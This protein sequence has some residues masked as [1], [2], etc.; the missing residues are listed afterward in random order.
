MKYQGNKNRIVK[1]ILPI[2]MS[3]RKPGQWYVEPFCGSCSVLQHVSESRIASDKNKY[4]IAMWKSLTAGK[5][6]PTEIVK[7]FYS[8]V[9]N[10]FNGKT[11]LKFLDM[12]KNFVE[13]GK[14]SDDLIGWVG[15]MAS[16]NGRFFDG[17][18]SGHKVMGSNGKE[19]DYIRENIANTM[20]QVP[21]LQDVQWQ[22]GDYYNI[23]IPPNSLIYCDPP[24]RNTKEYQ[25]S[26]GFDYDRFYDW[27]V[28]MTR[29]GHTVL[30]S[31]YEMP[32]D[33]FECIWSKEVTNA[34]NPTNTKKA[35]EK[36]FKVK[37]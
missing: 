35:V 31:E 5:R 21:Y 15:Y 19:R 23:E 14:Y 37:A 24:Y 28:D 17:G 4:L 8:D 16:F 3:Y 11:D 12:S 20:K 33:R 18:Y 2:I 6:M 30:V 27:C 9:R 25:F 32:E 13:D 29:K 10:C 26:R 36:L 22:S 1:D 7:D 34:M